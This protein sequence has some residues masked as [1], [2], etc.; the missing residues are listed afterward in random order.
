MILPMCCGMMFFFF[1]SRR[2]H[3]RCALVTGVQTCALPILGPGHVITKGGCKVMFDSVRWPRFA[4]AAA[5]LAAA[6]TVPTGAQAQ[7]AA[8]F[9]EGKVVTILIGHAP[10]GSYDLYAQ[11]AAQ[12]PG[13]QIR[14]ASCGERVCPYV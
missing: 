12:P 11:L 13:T 4:A 6:F 8:D 5:L 2:R 10:G 9:Y 7:D 1:S 14:R 3:T